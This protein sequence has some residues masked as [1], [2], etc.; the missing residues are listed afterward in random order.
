VNPLYLHPSAGKCMLLRLLWKDLCIA[1]CSYEIIAFV[2]IDLIGVM[3]QMLL[4]SFIVGGKYLTLD[5]N[6]VKLPFYPARNCF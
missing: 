1:N 2:L 3:T 4:G 5:T 6:L